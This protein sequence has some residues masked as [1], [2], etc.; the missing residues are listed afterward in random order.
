MSERFRYHKLIAS[1]VAVVC[2]AANQAFGWEA[3]EQTQ[4]Q[5]VNGVI[6]AL[7]VAGIYQGQT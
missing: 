5:I 7:M 1:M 3:D 6:A 2:F 4:E